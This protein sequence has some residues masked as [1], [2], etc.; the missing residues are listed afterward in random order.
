MLNVP[1]V[2]SVTV[3]VA[4]ALP[5]NL[6]SV[7]ANAEVAGTATSPM[8][9]PVATSAL[10]MCCLLSESRLA[11]GRQGAGSARARSR[12]RGLLGNLLISGSHRDG[13]RRSGP[14][15]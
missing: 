8:A 6:W 7:A 4:L 5:T 2:A 3:I 10:R 13:A 14:R 9:S 12:S 11:L 15:G 1:A